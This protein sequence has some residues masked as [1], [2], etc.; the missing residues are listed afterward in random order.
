MQLTTTFRGLSRAESASATSALERSASRLD[1]LLEQ[2]VPIRAVIEGGPPEHQ[3]TL[4][5]LVDGEDLV[6]QSSGHDLISMI[7]T[8]CER[9]RNQLLRM[10]DRRQTNR[11]RAASSGTAS[12]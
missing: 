1:R 4:S 11:Q 8:A 3:V 12:T 9:L 10:R 5:M 2:P 6:A 7:N